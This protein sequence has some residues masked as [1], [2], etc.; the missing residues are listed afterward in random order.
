[1]AR[2]G[3]IGALFVVMACLSLVVGVWIVRSDNRES[4]H[5]AATVLAMTGLGIVALILGLIGLV[6]LATAN[7]DS[8]GH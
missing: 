3:A 2:F 4:T 8:F 1:M 7:S 5:G 6:F